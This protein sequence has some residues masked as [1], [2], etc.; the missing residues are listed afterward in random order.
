[1]HR[2]NYVLRGLVRRS[3]AHHRTAQ[4]LGDSKPPKN[5]TKLPSTVP[6]AVRCAERIP[7]DT[8]PLVHLSPR[9]S[10]RRKYISETALLI[11]VR[12]QKWHQI[13][14]SR[15]NRPARH[16]FYSL[17]TFTT[18][19]ISE[20]RHAVDEDDRGG[21]RRQKCVSRESNAGPIDGNDGFYH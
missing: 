2:P 19:L 15:R 3:R 5:S 16:S 8:R 10:R 14:R 9:I 4:L 18:S 21:K 6:L 20:H 11:K 13:G 7:A 17:P 12:K 1:M